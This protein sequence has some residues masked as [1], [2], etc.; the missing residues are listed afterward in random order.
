ME[1]GM[2]MLARWYFSRVTSAVSRFGKSDRMFRATSSC[3]NITTSSES[4]LRC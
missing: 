3:E 1:R 4:Q 2:T